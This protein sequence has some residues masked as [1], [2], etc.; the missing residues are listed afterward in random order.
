LITMA[1]E[2]IAR[3]RDC[4]VYAAGPGRVLRRN[5]AGD[6]TERE[7]LLMRH[8][9]EQGYP[10]PAVHGADGPD[11]VMDRIDGPTMLADLSG[12]PW[13]IDAH[14]RMLGA[15]IDRLGTVGVPPGPMPVIGD[16]GEVIVHLDLHPDN[17]V[18]GAGGPIV[19]DW[20]NAALG[21]TGLDAANTWLTMAAGRPSGSWW[22][23]TVVALGRRVML[24]RYLAAIDRPRAMERLSTAFDQ[25]RTDPNLRADELDAMRRLV[26]RHGAPASTRTRRTLDGE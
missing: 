1:D 14:A 4:D 23:R 13:R 26:E 20:S 17:V 6:C 10:V 19:I 21:P 2:P 22:T 3:G 5:R 25:R 15:L 16:V 24:W 8:L 11:I 12:H 7:A 9:T 18:L